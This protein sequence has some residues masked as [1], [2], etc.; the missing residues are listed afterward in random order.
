MHCIPI[1]NLLLA[2]LHYY[3]SKLGFSLRVPRGYLFLARPFL[4]FFLQGFPPGH[5]TFGLKRPK[6]EPSF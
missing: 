1:G 2:Y 3:H 5:P 4:T 6:M